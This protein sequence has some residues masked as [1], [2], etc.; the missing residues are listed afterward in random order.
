MWIHVYR[1]DLL[2]APQPIQSSYSGLFGSLGKDLEGFRLLFPGLGSRVQGVKAWGIL[3]L[4][5]MG[6]SKKDPG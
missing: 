4:I 2:W 5:Y 1:K 3:S 6:P